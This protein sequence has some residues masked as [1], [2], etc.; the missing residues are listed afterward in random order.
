MVLQV[1]LADLNDALN[2]KVATEME[3]NPEVVSVGIDLDMNE[4]PIEARRW[5]KVDDV[6][7]VVADL[8]NST[9]L[10]TGRKDGSLGAIYEA[11]IGGITQIFD[12]FEVDYF[13]AQG[14]GGVAIFWGVDRYARAICAA[15]TVKTFSELT[16]VPKLNR[17][18]GEL[19]ETGYKIGIASGDVLV[20]K[21]GKP[22]N[23]E[24]QTPVWARDPVNYAAKCAQQSDVHKVLVTASVWGWVEENDYI[25]LSCGCKSGPSDS[26]WKSQEISHLRTDDDDRFGRVLSGKWCENC[27]DAFC[28]AVLEGKTKRDDVKAARRSLMEILSQNTIEQIVRKRKVDRVNTERGLRNIR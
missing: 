7:V 24:L 28:N 26:I 6:V 13:Q 22:R 10:A 2:E 20:K 17:K 19:P 11:A 25:A 21:V 14:D 27:G 15:I 9:R 4:L 16:L 18:F 23:L 5:I 12:S 1:D 3:S 8:R